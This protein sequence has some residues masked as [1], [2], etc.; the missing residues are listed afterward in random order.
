MGR[1]D[2]EVLRNVVVVDHIGQTQDIQ[3]KLLLHFHSSKKTHKPNALH[4]RFHSLVE[5]TIFQVGD[6]VWLFQCNFKTIK[7]H[8][9]LDYQCLSHSGMSSH[10][11]DIGF[12]LYFPPHICLHKML[13]ISILDLHSTLSCYS[14]IYTS[15]C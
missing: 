1:H 15:T 11:N 6:H 7:L 8:I 2:I 12:C 10:T 5:A 3:A 13:H 14:P 9:L 4:N